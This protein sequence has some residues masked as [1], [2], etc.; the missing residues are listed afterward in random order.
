[1][2]Q[3]ESVQCTI[4]DELNLFKLTERV[5]HFP[6]SISFLYSE[7]GLPLSLSVCVS[8]VLVKVSVNKTRVEYSK[9][10]CIV[11]IEGGKC[12]II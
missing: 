10:L 4:N 1:M 2:W 9:F 12:N 5:S 3:E 7:N 8:V 6:L 11:S